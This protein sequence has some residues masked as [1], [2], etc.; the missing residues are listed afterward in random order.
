MSQFFPGKL[1]Q[2]SPMFVD[3]TT[4]GGSSKRCLTGVGSGLPH[5]HETRVDRL[6]RDKQSD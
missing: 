1:F 6:A 3:K 5:K 2:P 4:Q